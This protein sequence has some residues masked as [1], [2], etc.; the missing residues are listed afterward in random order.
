MNG[1][2]S[3]DNNFNANRINPELLNAFKNNLYTK[4]LT[5]A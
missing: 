2:A 5:S 4:S 3:Y 1:L